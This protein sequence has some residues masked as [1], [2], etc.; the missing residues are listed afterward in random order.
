MKSSTP[1]ANENIQ[2]FRSWGFF[3]NA[4]HPDT[5]PLTVFCMSSGLFEWLRLPHGAATAPGSNRR[6]V[7]RV[8]E[9]L[10]HVIMYPDNAI[11]FDTSPKVHIRN[12]R[13][14]LRHLR[15]HHLK[16]FPSSSSP[17]D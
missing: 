2:H 12:Q 5:V 7:Q 6:F 17:S 1:S 16:L 10:E 4:I 14:L 8:A 15:T 13:E 11:A 9:G 3:Q